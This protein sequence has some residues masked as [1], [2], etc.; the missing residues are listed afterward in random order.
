MP[1]E[2]RIRQICGRGER[3]KLARQIGVH[4]VAYGHCLQ[5]AWRNATCLCQLRTESATRFVVINTKR[6]RSRLV[7]WRLC[8]SQSSV[9]A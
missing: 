9:P 5:G 1:R 7:E 8:E 6:P 3:A 4:A 2:V